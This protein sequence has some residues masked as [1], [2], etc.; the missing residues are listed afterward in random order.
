MSK[1]VTM[2]TLDTS[3]T[4]TGY[5]VWKNGL[6]QEDFG[7]LKPDTKQLGDNTSR[8]IRQIHKLLD[9]VK[10]DI[11]VVE[12]LNV[13]NNPKTQE[14]QTD[15]IGACYGYAIEH[16]IWFDRLAPND[17]RKLV[18]DDGEKIPRNR[19]DCKPWDINK[20]NKLVAIKTDDD[21]V[22]DAILIGE[23]Y[24]RLFS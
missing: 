23:A 4:N 21:D 14:G 15:I 13:Y 6:L 16:E 10:P 5:A 1:Q 24:R 22:A 20:L 9:R 18:A 19:N 7:V 11:L 12:G 8:M 2:V 17:W 3:T